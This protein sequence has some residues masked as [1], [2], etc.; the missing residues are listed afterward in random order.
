MGV[1]F[2]IKQYGFYFHFSSK[3]GVY[4]AGE[5]KYTQAPITSY[6]GPWTIINPN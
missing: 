6:L 5:D 2:R 4:F 3:C 1:Y